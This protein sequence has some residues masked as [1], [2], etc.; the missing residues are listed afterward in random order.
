MRGNPWYPAAL[1]LATDGR[2]VRNG[3]EL[4]AVARAIVLLAVEAEPRAPAALPWAWPATRA[5][6]RAAAHDLARE[7]LVEGGDRAPPGRLELT[8][9]GRRHLAAMK[10]AVRRSA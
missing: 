9:S 2:P 7:G 10:G 6:I 4:M 3:E 8:P 5:L 1:A